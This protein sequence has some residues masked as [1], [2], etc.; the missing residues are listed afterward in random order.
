MLGRVGQ[1]SLKIYS[2]SSNKNCQNCIHL[3]LLYS[4]T[5]EVLW[6]STV[7]IAIKTKQNQS[8]KTELSWEEV[9]ANFCPSKSKKFYGLTDYNAKLQ[10]LTRPLHIKLTKHQPTSKYLSTMDNQK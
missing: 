6:R 9:Q 3:K 7:N 4:N 10:S 1:N 8:V 5:R 2:N